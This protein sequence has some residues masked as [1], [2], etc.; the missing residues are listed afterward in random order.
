M[1]WSCCMLLDKENFLCFH[2]TTWSIKCLKF[3]V[4]LL[5]PKHK[6]LDYSCSGTTVFL[7]LLSI[8]NSNIGK[9]NYQTCH[10]P[11]STTWRASLDSFALEKCWKILFTR[12]DGILGPDGLLLSIASGYKGY[13]N[14]SLHL[15]RKHARIFVHRHYLFWEVNSFLRAL[16]EVNCG[17]W[18]TYNVQGQISKHIFKVKWRLLCSLSFKYL[19]QHAR[20][21]KL[22][23]I[24]RYSLVLAGEYSVMCYI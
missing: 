11:F 23:N 18:G 7:Y 17:L 13:I 8:F 16:L 3:A 1:Q 21:W 10:Y 15:A 2:A 5:L 14:N 4:V 20:F 22:G 6:S 19:S 12:A 9:L 24:L